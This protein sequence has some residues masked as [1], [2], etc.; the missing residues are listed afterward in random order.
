MNSQLVYD[1]CALASYAHFLRHRHL[2]TAFE[3][4]FLEENVH[5]LIQISLK[6]I[7]HGPINNTPSSVQVRAQCRAGNMQLSETSDDPFHW[8]LWLDI[9][10]GGLILGLR[11]ANERRRYFVPTS[12]IGWA[13]A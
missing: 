7:P 8:H 5:N 12:L 1:N 3:M 6:L 9:I 4:H 10:Y 11:P 13:Q 2:Q